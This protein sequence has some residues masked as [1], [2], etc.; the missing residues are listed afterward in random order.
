MFYVVKYMEPMYSFTACIF[1]STIYS[2][3]AQYQTLGVTCYFVPLLQANEVSFSKCLPYRLSNERQ[4]GSLSTLRQAELQT[5]A[6]KTVWL[7]EQ[8]L[9][10]LGLMA[11]NKS[12]LITEVLFF[13][14]H[15]NILAK[16]KP[17]QNNTIYNFQY[18]TVRMI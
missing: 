1:V 15:N 13:C 12:R 3:R 4:H 7:R 9:R 11:S 18:F 14:W 2:F 10:Q 17:P 5:F 8:T 6:R 16:G